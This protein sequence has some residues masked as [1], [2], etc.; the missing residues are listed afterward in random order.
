MSEED[1]GDT[2]SSVGRVVESGSE[3]VNAANQCSVKNITAHLKLTAL[4]KGRPSDEVDVE[5]LVDSGVHKTL[6]SERDWQK[7]AQGERKVKIKRCKV[8]FTPYGTKINLPCWVG[9]RPFCRPGLV[10]HS[11]PSCMWS[12]DRNSLCLV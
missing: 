6:L 8:N 5:L 12:R 7:L 3:K 11:G 9:P 2:D 1:K 4:D 10:P